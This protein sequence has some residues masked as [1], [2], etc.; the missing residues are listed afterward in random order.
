MVWTDWGFS[1]VRDAIKGDSVSSIDPS[2][3]LMGTWSGA[4]AFTDLKL[5]SPLDITRRW[6]ST[7]STFPQEARFE[8]FVG[9]NLI[10]SGSIVRELGMIAT[11]G[12]PIL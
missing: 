2:G 9:S 5:G 7:T 12:E 6:F 4:P 8:H 1:T 3:M 11:S 10:T